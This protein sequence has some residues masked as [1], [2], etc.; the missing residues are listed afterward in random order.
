MFGQLVKQSSYH[1]LGHVLEA[2]VNTPKTFHAFNLQYRQIYYKVKVVLDRL[3][4][5]TLK[6]LTFEYGDHW[7]DGHKDEYYVDPF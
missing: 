3:I 4:Y 6:E 2:L 7:I 5:L 1:T